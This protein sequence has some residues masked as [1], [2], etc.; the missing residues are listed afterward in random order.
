[1]P[2]N[3]NL[4]AE[5]QAAEDLRRRDP[6]KRAGLIAV[7]LVLAVL[8]WSGSL[9]VKLISEN[10]K[11]SRLESSLSARTNQYHQILANEARLTEVKGRLAALQNM[12]RDRFLTADLLNALQ[13]TSVNGV[14]LTRLRVEQSF[15]K[16]AD[17]KPGKPSCSERTTVILE[18]KDS[19][20]NP[21]GDDITSF[22]ESIAC[23][24][25]FQH[26]HIS[27]NDILLKN[28][29][30]PQVD[31]ENGAAFVAFMFECHYPEKLR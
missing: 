29:S 15:S 3:I 11:L 30:A 6:V 4:L 23:N 21:G 17:A 13:R 19:G 8:V 12:T 5:A 1:M 25:Y 28:L 24:P 20:S 2:I 26:A 31:T 7:V 9:Q 22:K 27:T 16:P 18:A 10:A 14:Q